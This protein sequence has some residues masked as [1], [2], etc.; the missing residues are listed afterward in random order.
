[1]TQQHPNIE[2]F[3][4][5]NKFK[6]LTEVQ[7]Q[8]FNPI[9]KGRDLIALSK[10][11]TGKTY[12][13]LLP[14]FTSIDVTSDQ[15][16]CVIICPTQELVEQTTRFAQNLITLFPALRIQSVSKLSDLQRLSTKQVPHVLI[17]SLGKLK[18]FYLDKQIYRIDH[19]KTLIIDEADMMLDPDNLIDLDEFA[20]KMPLKLQTLVFSAT[21]PNQLNKFMRTYMHNPV[22][23]NISKDESFDPRIEHILINKKED[24]FKKLSQLLK[25][26]NPALCIIFAKDSQELDHLKK[27]FEK[28]SYSFAAIH[29]QLSARERHQ[30]FKQIQDNTVRFVISTDLAARGLDLELATDVISLGFPSDLSFYT[31]RSGRI[32][33]AG[34]SGRSFVIYDDH[35]DRVIRKLMDIGLHFT[36]QSVND[37]GFKSLR[38]YGYTYHRKKTELDKDVEALVKG[39]SRKVKPGY[40]KKLNTEIEIIKRKHKRKIIQD[41][42]K[43]QKKEKAIIK[44]KEKKAGR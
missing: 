23:V 1:M 28:S 40:K 6:K 2:A 7:S 15:T 22:Q 38:S 17:G 18:S 24:I 41:S 31:H 33:R 5:L 11:G 8:T 35:D 4:K 9:I 44:Q 32:G 3:L 20:G 42:I 36:H 12:A 39:R 30:I 13:Y 43:A 27:F 37:K 25:N 21:I 10:T 29:G 14:S 16:Q 34:K 19:I 26:I